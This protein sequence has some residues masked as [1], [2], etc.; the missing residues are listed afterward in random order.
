MFDHPDAPEAG[1]QVPVG[2]VRPGETPKCAVL[3]EVAEETG[4]TDVRV[5][6][7]LA[8]DGRA[9]PV[10]RQPRLTTFHLLEAPGDG[11]STW[12]HRVRGEGNDAR[13]RF[14]CRFAPFPLP[15][16]LADAQDV[17]LGRVDPGW[18]P[19]GAAGSGG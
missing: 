17:W 5:M 14:V 2:G 11:P 16:P 13:M 6:R 7:R 9:H 19:P 10:T 18:A 3:R 8:V 12:E 4:L 1:V 15:E